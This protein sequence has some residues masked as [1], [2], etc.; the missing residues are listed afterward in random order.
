MKNMTIYPRFKSEQ[1]RTALLLAAGTGSRLSPLTDKK[2]KCLVSVNEISIL[3]RLVH[4]LEVHNFKR[5]VVVVGHQADVSVIFLE[6]GPGEWKLLI[7][8]V[9]YTKPPTIFI[10]YGLPE[11]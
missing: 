2:P 11:R 8:P 10:L 9:P 3:E 7:S 1:V 6:L 5:L 4:S